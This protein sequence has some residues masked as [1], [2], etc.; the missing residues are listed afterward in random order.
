MRCCGNCEFVKI[1]KSLLSQDVLH[2]GTC[3]VYPPQY[4]NIKSA[5][6]Y[7]EVS[8]DNQPCCNYKLKGE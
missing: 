3:R 7:P 6:L 5:W 1:T 2:I 8:I 4:I